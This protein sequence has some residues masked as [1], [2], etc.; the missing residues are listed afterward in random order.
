MMFENPPSVGKAFSSVKSPEPDYTCLD[1]DAI[2]KMDRSALETLTLGLILEN[3]I[4]KEKEMM[5]QIDALSGLYH[6]EYFNEA[7]NALF[8]KA[9]ST[10]G[11]DEKFVVIVLDVNGLKYIN[12]N[13]KNHCAGDSLLAATAARFAHIF[14]DTDIVARLGGDEFGIIIPNGH[15]EE[16]EM[17]LNALE[18]KI[19]VPLPDGRHINAAFSYG[20]AIFDGQG[21]FKEMIEKADEAMY[22]QKQERRAAG[23][24]SYIL[25]AGERP[26]V[27]HEIIP[28]LG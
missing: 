6:K 24:I 28:Y 17:R 16:I 12:D 20:S 13:E 5:A 22:D 15:I 3:N 19:L 25:P 9:T 23:K 7:G 14:R 10:L 18:N 27:S 2:A 21:S 26:P 11:E 4:L 1:A 8:T